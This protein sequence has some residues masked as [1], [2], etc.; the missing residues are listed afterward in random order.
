MVS[1]P[2]IYTYVIIVRPKCKISVSPT[3]ITFRTVYRTLQYCSDTPW[4]PRDDFAENREE[5]TETESMLHG[6]VV[7]RC[8]GLRAKYF[9]PTLYFCPPA[10]QSARSIRPTTGP[11]RAGHSNRTLPDIT[12]QTGQPDTHGS[13][14]RQRDIREIAT[15]LTRKQQLPATTTS[16]FQNLHM[17]CT[18][19]PHQSKH[20]RST[21]AP[22]YSQLVSNTHG[23][24]SPMD[25]PDYSV[26]A[27]VRASRSNLARA[28]RTC[29]ERTLRLSEKSWCPTAEA[30]PARERLPFAVCA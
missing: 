11:P 29:V 24:I 28:A 19:Q 2:G 1:L 21:M 8:N 10:M 27:R 23:D 5:G 17:R 25:E 22:S 15:I 26:G 18:A 9:L 4:H 16:H 6:R 3:Y 12:G 14:R 30:S 7:E 20:S 13:G